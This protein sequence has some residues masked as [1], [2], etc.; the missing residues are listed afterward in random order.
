M[1]SHLQSGP[2]DPITGWLSKAE[3]AAEPIHVHDVHGIFS[4]SKEHA[5]EDINNLGETQA[6]TYVQPSSVRNSVSQYEDG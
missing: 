3:L 2:S 1:Y 5:S 6:E 4:Q